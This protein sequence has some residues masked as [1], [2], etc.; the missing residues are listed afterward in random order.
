[1][2]IYLLLQKI[3]SILINWPLFIFVI[4]TSIVC[5]VAFGFIQFRYFIYA[6]RQIFVPSKPK[7]DTKGH[8]DM[9]PMQAFL[10]TLNSNL[11]NG[12]IAGVATG[13]YSGGPGSAF[14]I[15][16]FG[17]LL[18]A[19]RFAE[20]FLSMHFAKNA[21]AGC[22]LGGP[23]LYL[24]AAPAGAVLA[25]LYAFLCFIF[26]LLGA[27][28]AQTNSIALSLQTT[29]GITPLVCAIA[30]TLFILYIVFGGSARIVAATDKIVPIK[31][32]VFFAT[33][34]F[35]LAYHYNALG[36]AISLIIQSAFSSQAVTG[37][38][39]GFS[40]QQA[41]RFGMFRSIFATESGLGTSA[42]QFG[43]TGSK[44]PMKDAILAM[45]STFIS[46]TVC[47]IVALCIVAS[48]VWNSG[49][50]STALTIGAFNTAFGNLGGYVVSFLSIAFGVGVLVANAYICLETWLF[51]TGGRFSLLCSLLYCLFAFAGPFVDVTFLWALTDI[52][53]ACMLIINLWGILWLLP[54]IR[55]NV[56]AFKK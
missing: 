45:L 20:A 49:A 55:A 56:L 27:N 46:T 24:R 42:V 21:P 30:V 11:G 33:T 8:V 28:S 15:V 50:T 1:V 13:I 4:G 32:V 43:F 31:V 29:F 12:S 23:M 48:G 25:W 19:V 3:S 38:L 26:G 36:A 35:V 52:P 22:K 16:F 37:G 41:L 53:T 44:N 51:L 7:E 9:T 6:W 5:T 40:V 14:W 10:N 2:D 39:I 47:F 18:M 34:I 54:V 17:L